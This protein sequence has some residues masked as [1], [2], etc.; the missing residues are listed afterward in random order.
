MKWILFVLGAIVF[1][2]LSALVVGLFLPKAHVASRSAT[3]AASPEQVFQTITDIDRY[4]QWRS[5]LTALER[6]PDD[7]RGPLWMEKSGHNEILYRMEQAV[8]NSKI[9]TRIADPT[10]PFGGTWTFDITP[11]RSGTVLT[12]TEAGEVYNPFFRVMQ[13]LFF[14]PTAS[15]ETY[16][17]ALSTRLRR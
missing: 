15:I 8:P 16:L 1:L 10:L 11:Q 14:S 5:D 3:L 13:K 12:I 2:A 17:D 9:V 6:R 7:G 4:T